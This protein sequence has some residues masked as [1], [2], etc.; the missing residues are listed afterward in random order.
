[1]LSTREAG[2]RRASVELRAHR[3]RARVRV[4]LDL[5]GATLHAAKH[6]TRVVAGGSVWVA[7]PGRGRRRPRAGAPRSVSLRASYSCSTGTGATAPLFARELD[8]PHHRGARRRARGCAVRG[9]PGAAPEALARGRPLVPRAADAR[10]R[11][12]ARH[13]AVLPRPQRAHR[14]LVR[15]CASHRRARCSASRLRTSSSGTGQACTPHAAACGDEA[16]KRAR[17]AV[18]RRGSGPRFARAHRRR[19]ADR[20]TPRTRAARRMPPR[21]PGRPSSALEPRGRVACAVAAE[22]WPRRGRAGRGSSISS[23]STFAHGGGHDHGRG[24]PHVVAVERAVSS[25]RSQALGAPCGVD[26]APSKLVGDLR[27]TTPRPCPPVQARRTYPVRRGSELGFAPVAVAA[28][29]RQRAPPPRPGRAPRDRRR[30]GARPA[31]GRPLVPP[32]APTRRRRLPGVDRR[33]SPQSSRTRTSAGVPVV[34]FGAGTSLEGHVIPLRG[35][36]SLDLTR[37]N[38]IVAL[39]PDD[40]T[41]TVQAGRDAA[42]SSRPPPGRTASASRSTPAPTRRSAAWRRRTRAGRRPCA[43]AA[44]ARTCS[45]SR[46][47]SP[48]AAS[49]APAPA[50]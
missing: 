22:P 50:P 21:R 35:G 27:C 10:V 8:V 44:C 28:D 20:T 46:S 4:R 42:R 3:R 40:L 25:S 13:G 15:S 47:C 16:V 17:A 1:M 41:A 24:D 26:Q 48:T 34:P 38:A 14:R 31:R 19:G 43:T 12:R 37:L 29:L 9:A 18:S 32:A 49:S 5:A 36:I 33:R 30:V 6:R 2:G 45:R 23:I 39:R 7:R 11:R